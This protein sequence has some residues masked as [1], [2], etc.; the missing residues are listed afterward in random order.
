MRKIEVVYTADQVKINATVSLLAERLDA[1]EKNLFSK[2][3]Q[4]L[5]FIEICVLFYLILICL[6]YILIELVSMLDEQI[7][8][9]LNEQHVLIQNATVLDKLGEVLGSRGIQHFIFLGIVMQIEQIA[10]SYL[11]VLAEG[12]IQLKLQ[13]EGDSSDKIMKSV[14]VR[15]ADGEWKERGLSQLSGGQWRRVSMSLDLAFAE[16][17]RRRGALRCNVLVMDEVLTHLDASGRE[18]VGTVLRA[19]VDGIRHDDVVDVSSEDMVEDID[20]DENGLTTISRPTNKSDKSRISRSLLG[21]GAYETVVVIL[22][23]L[24]AMELEESFDHVDIVVKD[25]DTAK[26]VVDGVLIK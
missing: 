12:G 22:Q 24:A 2:S 1:A 23:D 5:F 11:T 14:Y 10:N 25:A 3:G 19:M 8:N 21:G 4:D 13:G 16:V 6:C 9:S 18:A 17:V 20:V 15:A 7:S 26:V